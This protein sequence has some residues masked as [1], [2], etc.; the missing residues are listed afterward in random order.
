MA[1]VGKIRRLLQI[2]EYL[3]SG[4]K[5]HTGQLSEFLGV[6]K[7]TIFRDLKVVQDSGVQLLYDEVELGYWVPPTTFLPPTD[8]TINETLALLV[9]GEKLGQAGSG[10][11][12]QKAARD[13][14]LKLLSN[15]PDSIRGMLSDVSDHLQIA[16]EP[17]H[18]LD[19]ANEHYDRVLEAIESRQKIRLEYESLYEGK[20]ISTLVSPYEMVFQKRSWY[21]VGRSS[22][23]RDIRTF[24]VGRITAS[25]LTSDTYEIPPRFT[26]K[27]Y[28]GN[29]WRMI[30]ELPE[31]E[32]IV[33]FRPLVARNVAEVLWHPTQ[34]MVWNDDGS[35]DFHARVEGIREISWW[36]LGY[37]DQA[38]VLAPQSLRELIISHVQR[39]AAVYQPPASP[40]EPG[41][42]AK[43][44]EKKPA[45]LRSADRKK[46]KS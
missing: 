26:L 29:A 5:Y 6:S 14:A 10:I 21:V 37:G 24:H 22:L 43:R 45:K 42:A 23:H 39:M 28:F 12:F 30:R 32:V 19:T 38:E 27:R 31:V 17:R 35:L 40:A 8:L 16:L 20:P 18:P 7:R 41:A 25:T 46:P 9:L 4:R 15:L 2:L 33:R 3:Q 44:V 34:K 13:A 11:P 36:I 1:S